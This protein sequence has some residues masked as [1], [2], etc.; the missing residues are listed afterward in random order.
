MR[1]GWLARTAFAF[2]RGFRPRISLISQI[3]P[4]SWAGKSS[5]ISDWFS[6]GFHRNLERST[7]SA[8]SFALFSLLRGAWCLLADVDTRSASPSLGRTNASVGYVIRVTV[9]VI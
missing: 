4:T 3:T 2:G 6:V 7:A 9:G 8:Q 5:F 1:S